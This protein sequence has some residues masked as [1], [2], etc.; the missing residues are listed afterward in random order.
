MQERS[1]QMALAR[2]AGGVIGT[3][4]DGGKMP[5]AQHEWHLDHAPSLQDV[6]KRRDAAGAAG[7]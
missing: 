7:G 5:V 3:H 6:L 4:T 1:W 2:H